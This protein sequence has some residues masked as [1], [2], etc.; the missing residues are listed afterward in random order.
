ME[1]EET[2]KNLLKTAETSLSKQNA[3]RI[4]FAITETNDG[5]VKILVNGNNPTLV[6]ESFKIFRKEMNDKKVWCDDD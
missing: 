4:N 6:L 3:P 2:M 1:L 5:E